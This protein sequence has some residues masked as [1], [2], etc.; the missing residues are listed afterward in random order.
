MF[1]N[2][3][4]ASF[5]RVVTTLP[6]DY[7]KYLFERVGVILVDER[8][9]ERTEFQIEELNQRDARELIEIVEDLIAR[10]HYYRSG[11]APKYL[12]DTPYD[13]F[14]RFLELDDYVFR[15]GHLARQENLV[16][17]LQQEED[18]LLVALRA[19][20][21]PNAQLIETHLTRSADA[22]GRDNNHSMTNSRQAL[23]QLLSD[24]ANETARA[25]ADVAPAA[26]RVR[27]Y[28][29]E[30]GF[31]AR[32]EKRGFSG[33]YGFLSGG[34]HPGIVDQEAAR[35]GRNFALG[36]CHYALQKYAGWARE[37]HRAF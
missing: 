16:V 32:E 4:I 3:T 11:V 37:G 1:S 23:E 36:S 8:S 26:E 22:Y 31:F 17:D 14:A 28:L 6:P 18:Q 24:I 30:C 29:E 2:R 19:S 27:E 33:A 25:R 5:K 9:A 20:G 21:L 34:P 12:F 13:D 7:R 10:T 15:D 35:L